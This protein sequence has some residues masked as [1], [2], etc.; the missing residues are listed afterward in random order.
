MS[1]DKA[2]LDELMKGRSAGDLFGKH[3]LLTGL[4]KA[5]AERVLSAEFDEYLSQQPL[6]NP[7]RALSEPTAAM[8]PARRQ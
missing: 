4:T 5:L 2:L 7:E 1:I 8:E 3:G 6:T